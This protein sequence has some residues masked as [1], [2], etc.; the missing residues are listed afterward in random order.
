METPGYGTKIGY[1]ADGQAYTDLAKVVDLTPPPAT[2]EKVDTSHMQS[3]D[4]WKTYDP[5]WKEAGDCEVAIQF[6]KALTATLYGL[7]AVPKNWQ[8]TYSDGSTLKWDGFLSEI[9]PETP[10]DDI[11]TV[12]LTIT[13]SGKPTYTP[14]GAGA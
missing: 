6:E 1:S 14:A 13:A 4:Q 2:V 10:M 3:P 12:G 5:S 9:G 7:L 8:I 11:V